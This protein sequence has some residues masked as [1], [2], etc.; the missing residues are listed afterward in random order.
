[1]RTSCTIALRLSGTP[2]HTSRFTAGGGGAGSGDEEVALHQPAEREGGAVPCQE[3]GSSPSTLSAI[4]N[5]SE[6]SRSMHGSSAFFCFAST[7]TLIACWSSNFWCRR[8]GGGLPPSSYSYSAAVLVG[9]WCRHWPPCLA[10]ASM[11]TYSDTFGCDRMRS[12]TAR[13]TAREAARAINMMNT[14][15]L[16]STNMDHEHALSG[17]RTPMPSRPPHHTH[18]RG[19]VPYLRRGAGRAPGSAA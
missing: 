2:Q 14:W 13:H 7:R 10:S 11:A 3:E 15:R 1:M 18:E 5:R 9:V 4:I 16:Q 12:I 17:R 19:R 8:G 6:D